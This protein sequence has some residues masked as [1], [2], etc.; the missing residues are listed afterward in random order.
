MIY[1]KKDLEPKLI[2]KDNEG[3]YVAVQCIIQQKKVLILSIYAP[4]GPKEKFFN[5]LKQLLEVHN[6]KQL[7][8][9]DFNGT[10]NNKL[11]RQTKCT[12]S[13]QE[14][15]LP[16]VFF[17]LVKQ[18]TLEDVWRKYNPQIKEF[19][20]Y[21]KRN[22]P[23]S[24]IMI[25]P[26]KDIAIGTKEIEIFPKVTSDHNRMLLSTKVR[27]KQYIWRINKDLLADQENIHVPDPKGRTRFEKCENLKG[28]I[29]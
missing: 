8:V 11:D 5:N 10:V 1:V 20:F 17:E 4:N 3:R 18:E 27:K 28:N 2:F 19:T 12:M 23:F 14:G 9:G 6:F 24:R 26:T 15:K 7:L 25:W 21:S 22:P 16:K 29:I 13:I